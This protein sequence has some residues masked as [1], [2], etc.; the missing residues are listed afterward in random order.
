MNWKI[1][2]QNIPTLVSNGRIGAEFLLIPIFLALCIVTAFLIL[3][4]HSKARRVI[5]SLSLLILGI[6]F[7]QCLCITKQV[8][9][10]IQDLFR[11]RIYSFLSVVWFPVVVIIFVIFLGRR[12]YCY[13]ICPLGFLQDLTGKTGLHK[14]SKTT[15]RMCLIVLLIVIGLIMWLTHP[16]SIIM[17]AGLG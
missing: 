17:G 5:Q 15:R 12:Y 6:I 14:T 16:S 2:K 9:W 11:G 3:K 10:G 7:L 4:G 13:W 8:V 1:F